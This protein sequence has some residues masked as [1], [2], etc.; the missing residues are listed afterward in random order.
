MASA[1]KS[2]FQSQD[3]QNSVHYDSNFHC[4]MLESSGHSA[5]HVSENGVVTKTLVTK[6]PYVCCFCNKRYMTSIKLLQH[7]KCHEHNI[8]KKSTR[9][10]ASKVKTPNISHSMNG[11]AVKDVKP[12]TC[13]KCRKRFRTRAKLQSHIRF[14]RRIP[15][16]TGKCPHCDKCY[17]SARRLQT[18]LQFSHSA[19]VNKSSVSGDCIAQ[20][21]S[22]ANHCQLSHSTR[23]GTQ[24]GAT[25][26][27]NDNTS[28]RCKDCS[29][30]SFKTRRGLMAHR[31]HTHCA[32]SNL[33]HSCPHCPR[34]FLYASGLRK[35]ERQHTGNRP[36]V[37]AVCGKGFFNAADLEVHNHAHSGEDPVTCEVCN[38]WMSSMTVLRAHM[39]V[40]RPS[41]S[42]NTCMICHKHFS[43]LSSLRAHMKRQHAKTVS[44]GTS[45]SRQC[46]KCVECSA[47]FLSW[48]LLKDHINSCHNS[49]LFL[50]LCI[51]LWW[52]ISICRTTA[53]LNIGK[54]IRSKCSLSGTRCSCQ[55]STYSY[56]VTSFF[57]LNVGE[58][59]CCVQYS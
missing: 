25:S 30:D 35:H 32:G 19:P 54:F 21:L 20:S 4:K 18:H 11:A 12:V 55:Y 13:K 34:Q 17:K 38:K 15:S 2:A 3:V 49:R 8:C 36:H 43:Y 37:C 9:F 28:L 41:A 57:D 52:F 10:C 23:S 31:R 45:Q 39:Q 24:I 59:F 1:L 58:M 14:C 27:S 5:Q 16:R 48:S 51:T 6:C 53:R 44:S 47:Q 7:L 42:L 33:P 40:H 29:A 22:F 26:D 46:W 56:I 50:V